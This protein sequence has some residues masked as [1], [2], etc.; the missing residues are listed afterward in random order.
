MV[1]A[2]SVLKRGPLLG[3]GGQELLHPIGDHTCRRTGAVF[4]ELVPHGRTFEVQ[5]YR[6]GP[7]APRLCHETGGGV[8]VARGADGCKDIGLG[9][10]VKNL[11]HV[12]GHFA[13]PND[14]GPR[15]WGIAGGAG[16]TDGHDHRCGPTVVAGSAER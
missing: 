11:I 15:G 16:I 4:G 7:V 8:D 1:A 6:M 13:E 10:M 3:W 9:Q 12:I 2:R 5:L 14:V